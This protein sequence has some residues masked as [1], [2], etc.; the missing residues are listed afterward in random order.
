MFVSS[1][2]IVFKSKHPHPSSVGSPYPGK[3]S[4]AQRGQDGHL[5]IKLGNS[6]HNGVCALVQG[7]HITPLMLSYIMFAFV[8]SYLWHFTGI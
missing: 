4:L 2:Q 1:L 8:N 3:G 6:D 7:C 5:S